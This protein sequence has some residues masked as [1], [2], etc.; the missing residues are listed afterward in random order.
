MTDLH[1]PIV[2][3]LAAAVLGLIFAVLSAQVVAGRVS[4]KVLIGAGGEDTTNPLFIAIRCQANFAEY[5]PLA[6]LLIGL[7]ELRTGATP[8]VDGLA[9]A[10]VIARV[11][12]PV[13]M[14]LPAPNPFRAGGFIITVAVLAVASVRALLFALG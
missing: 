9:G 11:M 8:L 12:H 2:T 10:L 6:L 4:G 13:G 14:R 5:V 7:I 1:P 3:T